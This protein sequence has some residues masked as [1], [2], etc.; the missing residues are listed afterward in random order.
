MSGPEHQNIII[1]VDMDADYLIGPEGAHLNISGIS[2][3]ATKTSYAMFLMSAIQQRQASDQWAND[4]QAS[5]VILNVKGADLLRLHEPAQDMTERT[6]QEWANCD[7][8][9]KPLGNISYYYPYSPNGAVRAQTKLEASAV[10]A[11]I[12]AGRAFRYIYDVDSVLDRLLLLFEDMDDPNSTL[13]SCAEHCIG[14]TSRNAPWNTLRSNVNDW[15]AKTPD[16]KIPVVSWRRFSRLFGREHETECSPNRASGPVTSS[17][18]SWPRNCGN[19]GRATLLLSISP[20]CP[21]IYRDLLLRTLFL[22]CAK[23][24]RRA[25][26]KMRLER[27]P[28]AVPL[29]SLLTN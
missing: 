13:V 15:A 9:A 22:H 26:K 20:N 12:E 16:S 7:L 4:E 21:T 10:V 28:D 2:G 11:N 19:C 24:E 17:R 18:C 27:F 29:F 5:F 8:E 14:N 1:N 6:G 3:L 23:R 25:R